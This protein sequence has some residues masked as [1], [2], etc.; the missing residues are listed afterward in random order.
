MDTTTEHG[1]SL[2]ESTYVLPI[3]A[4]QVAEYWNW[5]ITYLNAQP[6][7]WSPYYE[8]EDILDRLQTGMMQGWLYAEKGEFE[9]LAITSFN[10]YGRQVSSVKI[11]FVSVHRPWIVP[12]F[13]NAIEAMAKHQ[14]FILIEAVAHPTIA[15]YAVNKSGWSAPAVY[16]MKNLRSN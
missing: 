9:A 14:K 11:E 16:I 4:N 3:G 12:K 7:S 2:A 1:S 10:H 6:Q 5:I 15:E 13:M 8:I